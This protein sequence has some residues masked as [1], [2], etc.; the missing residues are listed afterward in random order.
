MVA[1]AWHVF[2]FDKKIVKGFSREFFAGLEENF[3]PFDERQRI[4]GVDTHRVI[5]FP[6]R[7]FVAAAAVI[8]SAIPEPAISQAPSL[9]LTP[10]GNATLTWNA[11]A[12]G[13]VNVQ[14]SQ[15]LSAW[16]VVAEGNTNGTFTESTVGMSMAFYRLGKMVFVGGN[17]SANIPDLLVSNTETTWSEWKSVRAWAVANGYDLANGAAEGN[18]NR[19]PVQSV[20]WFD[21]VKWCNARSEMEGL[22]P[23]YSVNGTIYRTGEIVPTPNFSASGY[24]LPTEAEWAWAAGGGVRSQGTIYSGSNSAAT[25]AWYEVNSGGAPKPVGT[26]ASNELALF[27]MSGNVLEWCWDAGDFPGLRVVKGGFWKSFASGCQINAY[28]EYLQDRRS[29][30]AGFRVVRRAGN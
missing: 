2:K 15:N 27:D 24:R 17:S 4:L 14:R 19:Q 12:S 29:T 1:G 13:P 26:K 30:E 20:N 21:A 25:V 6:S 8:L 18:D 5:C 23:I 16:S 22:S 9:Q 3:L 28:F 7:F 10:A 11:T